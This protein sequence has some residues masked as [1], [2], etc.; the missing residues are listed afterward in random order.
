MQG[1]HGNGMGVR[2]GVT[3]KA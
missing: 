3:F 2:R 1:I